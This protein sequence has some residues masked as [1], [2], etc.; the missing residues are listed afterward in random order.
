VVYDSRSGDVSEYELDDVSAQVLRQ[1]ATPRTL[2][3]LASSFSHIAGF[4]PE[5]QVDLLQER[6]LL[7]QEDGRFFSLVVDKAPRAG[8]LADSAGDVGKVGGAVEVQG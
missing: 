6:G 7:F 5:G 3:G 8:W 2:A 1:L 4:D